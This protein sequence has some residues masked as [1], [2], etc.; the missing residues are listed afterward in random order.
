MEMN[1][2]SFIKYILVFS[3]ASAAGW[4]LLKKTG[5]NMEPAVGRIIKYPGRIRPE[6]DEI[7]RQGSWA[8]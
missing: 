8:G 3:A 4:L 5:S 1:R 6:G 2:R 7:V